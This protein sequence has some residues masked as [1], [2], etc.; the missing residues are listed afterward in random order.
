MRQGRLMRQ[1]HSVLAGRRVPAS[2]AG[3]A[4]A[5]SRAA[6]GEPEPQLVELLAALAGKVAPGSSEHLLWAQQCRWVT[7]PTPFSLHKD[8]QEHPLTGIP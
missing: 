3:A 2:C 1:G 5:P 7:A 6:V 4:G 8:S